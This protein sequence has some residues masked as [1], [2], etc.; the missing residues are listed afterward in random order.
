[1]GGRGEELHGGEETWHV[2]WVQRK[3]Y[4]TVIR[5]FCHQ[6]HCAVTFPLTPSSLPHP[7]SEWQCFFLDSGVSCSVERY[8]ISEMATLNEGEVRSVEALRKD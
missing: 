6:L 7:E 1:M 8:K 5:Y 2:E 4:S 3:V